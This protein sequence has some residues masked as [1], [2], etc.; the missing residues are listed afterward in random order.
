[1]LDKSVA[2]RVPGVF[3]GAALVAFMPPGPG[4]TRSASTHSDTWNIVPFYEY[5]ACC[6]KHCDGIL[7]LA[8]AIDYSA[9]GTQKHRHLRVCKRKAS[10][11]YC[12]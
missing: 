8:P 6:L 3:G 12:F 11:G 4:A 9:C 2:K 5:K 7:F 10:M 1:M